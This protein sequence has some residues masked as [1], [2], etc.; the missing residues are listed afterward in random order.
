M[1]AIVFDPERTG[2][3]Q[4]AGL[5]NAAFLQVD[6]VPTPDLPAD[7]WAVIRSGMTGICGSDL[8]ILQGKATP[9][10]EPYASASFIL[11]HELSGTVEAVGRGARG[12]SPGDRVVVDP[13]LACAERGFHPICP[14]CE[15]G[16]Q[17]CE[18][19]AQGCLEPGALIGLC[20][21]TGGG[22]GEYYVAKSERV[23]RVPDSLSDQT[24]SLVEPLAVSMRA[25]L[26]HCP[27]A[28]EEV[29]VIGAGSIGLF[30]IA[31]LRA[32]QPRCHITALAKYDFQGE[33]AGAL[34]AD[35]VIDVGTEDPVEAIGAHLQTPVYTVSTGAKVLA[36]GVPYVYDTVTNAP[37]LNQGLSILGSSG[38]LV[39]LGVPSVPVGVD[40]SV[41][42]LKEI[43]VVGSLMYGREHFEGS[44]VPTF[45]RALEWLASGRA[46]VEAI[47]PRAFPI[48][49]F[50]E[51]LAAASDKAGSHSVKIS[52]AF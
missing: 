42:V 18:R 25:V 29:V 50:G 35:R 52:F 17:G 10:M 3:A 13:T 44:R 33:W 11:G 45:A 30:T 8:G 2:P 51:A 40:W 27:A 31:A 15:R 41:M 39:L 9:A 12:L 34:G 24:A 46:N 20:A 7:D 4:I 21:T 36:G 43:R 28:G 1:R 48:D 37:S 38:R 5:P 49:S 32:A 47:R 16:D 22:W 26:Q 14:A 19:R 6:E 23:H